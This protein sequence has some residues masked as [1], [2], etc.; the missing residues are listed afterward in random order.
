MSP[1]PA[2]WQEHIAVLFRR[3]Q[4]VHNVTEQSQSKEPRMPSPR[5]MSLMWWKCIKLT[6]RAEANV[7]TAAGR[8]AALSTSASEQPGSVYGVLSLVIKKKK[9]KST[10]PAA[11]RLSQKANKDFLFIFFFHVSWHFWTLDTLVIT[12]APQKTKHQVGRSLNNSS[13]WQK[14]TWQL[15]GEH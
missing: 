4:F 7:S 5:K 15:W 9:K 10:A 1:A 6:G 11:K 2:S 12:D 3:A 8:D 14:E 13:C